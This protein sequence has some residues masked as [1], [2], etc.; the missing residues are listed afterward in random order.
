MTAHPH[1]APRTRTRTRLQHQPS[2]RPQF[3]PL[4]QLK[5]AID[6]TPSIIKNAEDALYHLTTKQWLVPHQDVT[7]TQLASILLS[8]V[9]S[10][11]QCSTSERISENIANVIKAIAFLI[12]EAVVTKYAETIA[13]HLA[14]NLTLH[15]TLHPTAQINAETTGNVLET[16]ETLNKSIQEQIKHV[17]N[18]SEKIHKIQNSLPDMNTNASYRDTLINGTHNNLATQSP[19]ANITKAKLQNRI[20]I[21]ACQILIEVQ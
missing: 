10:S 1:E 2:T 14:G 16:L 12:E 7:S 19:P 13:S 8:L 20:N 21:E 5:Q 17:K 11:G 9:T 4:H 6:N 18:A 3:P 15:P